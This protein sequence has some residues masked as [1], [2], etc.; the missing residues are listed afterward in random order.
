[1][2]T[3]EMMN[4]AQE[5]GRTYKSNDMLYSR[6]DGFHSANGE[7]WD[8]YAFYKLN[9]LLTLEWEG[10]KSMTKAEAEAKYNILI[11]D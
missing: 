4:K 11:T 2:T 5:T 6:F 8:G 7:A 9:D 3:L 1:M 10:P